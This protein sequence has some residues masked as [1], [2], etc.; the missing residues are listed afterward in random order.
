MRS[1]RRVPLYGLGLWIGLVAVSLV[2]LPFEGGQDALYESVKSTALVAVVLGFTILYMRRSPERSFGLGEGVLV[3]TLW[4][5]VVV[6]LD[7]VLY[8]LGAFTIGLAEY[9]TDVASS[10]L[11][12]P[13]ITALAMSFLRPGETVG[14]SVSLGR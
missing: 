1:L 14:S 9:F 3:G 2:L 7:L 8:L 4:A 10:Y 13:V 12:I 5:A 11:A 6:A